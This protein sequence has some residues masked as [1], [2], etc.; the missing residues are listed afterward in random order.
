MSKAIKR[1]SSQFEEI[2]RLLTLGNFDEAL[3][4]VEVLESSEGLS[5]K[6]KCAGLVLKSKL[7]SK[8]GNYEAAKR[9][10]EQACTVSSNLSRSLQGI[11][12]HIALAE[13]LWRLGRF[14]EALAAIAEGES[15]LSNLTGKPQ[16]ALD[17]RHAYFAHQK[18]AIWIRQ[19]ELDRALEYLQQS[20]NLWETLGMQQQF[21]ESN[22]FV[23]IIYAMKGEFD[24]AK[25]YHEKSLAISE[26]LGIKLEIGRS[27]NNIGIACMEQ[28]DLDCAL[29]HYEQCLPPYEAV[30]NKDNIAGALNNLGLVYRSKG[31]LKRALEYYHK[32]LAILKE[33]NNKHTIGALLTNMGEIYA[34]QG[35]LNRALEFYQESLELM[36]ELGNKH[37]F[38]IIVNNMGILSAQ[39]GEL[40]FA[41]EYLEQSL[42]V[43][44][45]L[46]NNLSASESLFHLISVAID[47]DLV[48]NASAYLQRLKQIADEEENVII[49]QYYCLA[50]A[51]VLKASPRIKDKANAQEALKQLVEEGTTDYMLAMIAMLNLCELL[52][53]ELKAY[54]EAI[55]LEEVK[56]LVEK[57]LSI[58]NEQNSFL[59]AVNGR[60]LQAKLALVEGDLISSAS[61]LDQA[62]ATAEKKDLVLLVEKAKREQQLLEEQLE[63]WQ[64]LIQSNPPLQE[65]LRRTTITEYLKEALNLARMRSDN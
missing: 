47:R 36:E 32:G 40:Q 34:A 5:S 48:E 49:N 33:T 13:A 65:R 62:R 61:L 17:Q 42:A 29:E 64:R 18:G 2:E 15:I 46:G 58:A 31:E 52:L 23:G 60:I 1:F 6:E 39:K 7:Q 30:G 35:E 20:L 8:K 10:A 3:E 50:D 59:L 19:G 16:A 24:K 63:N 38:G 11:D 45:E 57:L 28:G 51:L 9:I 54:G 43:D 37:G 55:V 22:N 14:D 41:I 4:I 26:E 44:E 27:L 56:S 12:A 25:K 21:A 53:D